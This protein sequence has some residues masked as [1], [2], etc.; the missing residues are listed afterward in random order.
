MSIFDFNAP[1]STPQLEPAIEP[2]TPAVEPAVTPPVAPPVAQNKGCTNVSLYAES[3]NFSGE[4]T[5]GH[6]VFDIVL[7]ISWNCD[8]GNY[9]TA[10][11][12]KTVAFDKQSLLQQALAGTDITLV[13]NKKLNNAE[14]ANKMMNKMR[15]L[16]GI[17]GKR[18]FV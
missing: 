7:N 18:T 17:S 10:K 11:I 6:T 15:E 8:A 1:A 9:Q 13:E 16:A 4:N 12:I 3:I 14:E 5:E 2:L